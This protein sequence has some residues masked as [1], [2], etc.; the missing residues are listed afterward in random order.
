MKNQKKSQ[1]DKVETKKMFKLGGVEWDLITTSIPII[2]APHHNLGPP[3]LMTDFSL[4]RT[5]F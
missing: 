5:D 3:T 4:V 1:E 2:G